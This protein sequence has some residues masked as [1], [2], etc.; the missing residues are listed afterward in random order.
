MAKRLNHELEVLRRRLHLLLAERGAADVIDRVVAIIR[1]AKDD[2]DSKAK[3]MAELRYVPHGATRSVPIDDVQAE[4]ILD[5]ALKRINTLNRFRINEEIQQKGARADEIVTILASADGVTNIVREELKDV[6]KRFGRPRRTAISAE[7]TSA[8]GEILSANGK[9][10][11]VVLASAPSEEVWAYVTSDGAVLVTPRT[12]RGPASAPVKLAGSASLVAVAATWSD[13]RLLVFTEQGQAVRA[14][15]SDQP[16]GRTGPGRPLLSPLG[17]DT[18]AAVFSGED[19]AYYLLVSAGGQVKRIPATTVTNAS[20]AGTTCC[21]VPEGDRIVAVVAH[22]GDDEIL[23][24]KAGGQVLRLETGAKLRPVP[25]GAAGMVAGVKV[26]S[27]DG[28]V[29]AVRAEG[30]SLLN[31][32]AS[33]LALAVALGEYPVKGRGAGGV[34]SV[35]IDRPAKSPAGELAL[36]VCQGA[37]GE[38]ELFTDRGGVYRIAPGDNPV[39]RRATNSRPFLPL[40]PG[41]TPRGQVQWAVK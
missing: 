26:D 16:I 40:G 12:A 24:A 19:A 17:Q 34:Q 10:K 1:T 39:V 13:Q 14:T 5:M 35:L 30:E 3:L 38:T 11:T 15:L 21:R 6:R 8:P 37:T 22:G 28:V 25:T 23:I 32:H 20:A 27:G 7:T 36:I 9:T 41:E 4:H 18:I 33:G 29:S 31:L 2:D